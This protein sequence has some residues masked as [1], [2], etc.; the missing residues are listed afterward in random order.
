[1]E[2]EFKAYGVSALVGEAQ[3]L[4]ILMGVPPPPNPSGSKYLFWGR[5]FPQPINDALR[6]NMIKALHPDWQKQAFSANTKG[7][8]Q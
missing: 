2:T 3:G 7:E 6:S 1:M 8:G 4:N 5:P